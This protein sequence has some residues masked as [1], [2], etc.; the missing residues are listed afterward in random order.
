MKRLLSM[1]LIMAFLVFAVGCGVGVSKSEGGVAGDYE[2]TEDSKGIADDNLVPKTDSDFSQDKIIR[3]GKI[4]LFTDDYQNT[5]DKITSYVT[6]LDGFIQSSNDGYV[7]SNKLAYG[8]SGFMVVRVPSV[9]FMDSMEEIKSYGRP[10]DSSTN[11]ENITG[12]YK[13]LESELKSFKIEEERLLTYLTKAEKIEDMLT[14]EKELTRVRTEINS[15]ASILNNYDK[16]VAFST[17]TINL[18]E[19]KS[20]TGNIDSPFSDF[21]LKISSGFAASIN[22]MLNI[23]AGLILILIRLLPFLIIVGVA[24]LILWFFKKKNRK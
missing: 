1:F 6:G 18:T 16:L 3:N 10:T 22:L 7:D 5:V 19:S 15:R 11:T 24:L 21:G 8:S 14:I 13:D 23:L 12:T 4:D 17:I 9:K 20:A 2:V